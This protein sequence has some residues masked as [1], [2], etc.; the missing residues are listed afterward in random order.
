MSWTLIDLSQKVGD[1][2]VILNEDIDRPGSKRELESAQ[3]ER[4]KI[5]VWMWATTWFQN[6]CDK[7]YYSLGVLLN[8]MFM[9][10]KRRRYYNFLLLS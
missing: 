4:S 5:S 6:F 3:L 10:L 1:F 8:S 2:N 7:R 9:N